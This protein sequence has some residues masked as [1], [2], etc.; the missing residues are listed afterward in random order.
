MGE[1][2]E[3]LFPVCRQ[4]KNDAVKNKSTSQFVSNETLKDPNI[5][6]S[7]V[8]CLPVNRWET[9]TAALFA[10]TEMHEGW[11]PTEFFKDLPVVTVNITAAKSATK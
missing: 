11:W 8:H 9:T 10:E 4:R 6:E 7:T 5:A 3:Q 2:N 1:K